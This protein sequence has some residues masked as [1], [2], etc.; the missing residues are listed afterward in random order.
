M[1]K[2]KENLTSQE[3]PLDYQVEIKNMNYTILLKENEIA[4]LKNVLIKNTNYMKKLESEIFDLKKQCANNYELDKKI[5]KLRHNNDILQKENEKL[6]QDILNQKKAYLE[7]KA[8]SEKLFNARINQMQNTI[9]NYNQKLENTNK[10]IAENE[11]LKKLNE[12]LIKERD[13]TIIKSEKDLVD[14]AVKNKLKFSILKKKMMENIKNSQIKV[15][16][17]NMQYMDVSAKLTLLQN[18]QL[19]TQLEYLQEQLDEYQ[20]TNELLQ[21]K[22][23]D[24]KKDIEI[25]KEV[26]LSLA[27]K[28]KK[29]KNELLREKEDKDDIKEDTKDD[30]N[31]EENN[32]NTEKKRYSINQEMLISEQKIINLEQKL[33]KKKKDFDYL[34]DKYDFIETYLRNYEK[35]FIGIINFLKDSLDKFFTDEELLSNHDVNIHLEDIKNGDFSSLS[36]EG[37][38]S[39]L[40]ILMKYLMPMINQA[41]LNNNVKKVNNVNLKFHLPEIKTNTPLEINKYN[42]NHLKFKKPNINIRSMSAENINPQKKDVL[43]SFSGNSVKNGQLKMFWK[44]NNKYQAKN[45]NSSQSMNTG[46][47]GEN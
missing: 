1:S 28:N 32:Q 27:E 40:I 43:P 35:K 44:L 4:D 19:L 26:E 13:A 18:H 37:Q 24:L 9:D 8:Q 6:N 15:T 2:K 16:E 14:L 38:Y 46:I 23:M 25:H 47:S 11:K 7:E 10:I 33:K 34:K 5:G 36:K 31:K 20:R 21:K 45:R 22:N 3:I 12:E 30:K 39:T 42:Y 29:L 17:L 41:K